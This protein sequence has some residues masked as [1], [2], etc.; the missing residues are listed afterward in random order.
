MKIEFL[1]ASNKDVDEIRDL[2]FSILK[3]YGLSPDPENT[4]SDI[5]DIEKSYFQSGGYFEVLKS[6]GKIIGTWGLYPEEESTF[7]LRKMYL[8]KE[9][10]G[11]GLGK[12]MMNRMLEK[13]RELKCERIVLETA[14][15]LKEA[16]SMYKKY[17]F[18]KYERSHVSCRCDQ[19]YYLTLGDK[20][21]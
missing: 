19:C 21:D 9:A 8:K 11:R 12:Q 6:D 10:R 5:N 17:G 2:I 15:V 18:E 20:N 4:D 7:E 16:I 3:E 14:S 13:A 1:P